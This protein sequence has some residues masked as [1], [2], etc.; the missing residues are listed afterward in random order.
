ME[1]KL[2]SSNLLHKQPQSVR[3]EGAKLA[4]RN[5][6]QHLKAARMLAGNNN[7]GNGIS[8]LVLSVEETI[9]A[10][11]L[12]NYRFIERFPIKGMDSLLKDIFR[13]HDVKQVSFSFLVLMIELTKKVIDLLDSD[14]KNFTR[15]LTR[16]SDSQIESEK[17]VI[18]RMQQELKEM[19]KSKNDGFYVDFRNGSWSDP[20][21][22][23]KK[24]SQDWKRSLLHISIRLALSL[25]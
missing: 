20:K 4:Y 16:W 7:Y 1:E 12:F 13:K 10:V 19:N 17:S 8:H 11:F 25:P 2:Q 6:L 21:K 15:N 24:I 3:D 5:A 22:K 9:K 18:G 23:T 14:R